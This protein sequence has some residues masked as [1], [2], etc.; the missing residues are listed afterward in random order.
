MSVDLK[1]EVSAELREEFSRVCQFSISHVL[2][3]GKPIC[4]KCGQGRESHGGSV[5]EAGSWDYGP[6]YWYCEDCDYE[7]GHA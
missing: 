1:A 2:R 6:L 7:W 3:L 5:V 4:P